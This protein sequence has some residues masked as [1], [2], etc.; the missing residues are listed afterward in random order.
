MTNILPGDAPTADATFDQLSRQNRALRL[1]TGIARALN[2]HQ[3]EVTMLNEV[4]QL[5]VEIGNYPV[6]WIA[7]AGDDESGKIA[8]LAGFCTGN[9][10]HDIQAI[11]SLENSQDDG[12]VK[13]AM[14]SGKA[15]THADIG[16]ASVQTVW[17]EQALKQGLRSSIALPLRDD[18]R[19][20]GTLNLYAEHPGSFSNDEL[21]LLEDIVDEIGFGIGMQRSRLALAE[22]EKNLRKAQD[23]AHLGHFSF[24]PIK[25]QWR[26]SSSLDQIFGISADYPRTAES[27]LD[28]VHPEDQLR[29]SVYLSEE[30]IGQRRTF[31]NEYRI[32][33]PADG[34]TRWVHGSGEVNVNTDNEVV[35]MFGAI[36]DITDRR[37]AEEQLTKLSLALEQSPHSILITN[38]KIEIEYI[39]EGF[40]QNTGYNRAEVI[41]RKPS[42]LSSGLTPQA[43]YEKL[44]ATLQRGE[45]WR[46]EFKNRRKDGE[47]RDAF[48]IISPVRQDDGRISHFLSIEEDITEKK[49][50]AE[51]LD[52]HRHHLEALVRDRTTELSI[53]KEEAEAANRA[54]TS[55]VANMSHEIRTPMNAIIGLT[56]LV[57]REIDDPIQQQRL[58]K[59]AD[60]AQHLLSIINDILDISKI[61]AGKMVLEA[62]PF[63]VE[64]VFNAAHSLINERAQL[65][66]LPVIS[67]IDPGLPALL[68][69]DPLRLQQILVNFLSN[70]VKFTEKGDIRIVARTLHENENG[71][72]VRFEVRDTGIGMSED[73]QARL[74]SPFEQADSSTTRRYGGTGLGLAISRRLAEAMGGTIGVNSQPGAGSTFWFT[75]RLA[76]VTAGGEAQLLQTEEGNDEVLIRRLHAGARVLLVEDNVVNQ[77]VALDLLRHAGLTADLAQ[78]G[79]EATVMSSR[80]RYDL[81]LMDMQMPVLDGIGATRVIRAMPQGAK[82]PI[83]AMTANAFEEDR[84][85]CLD[86]GMN[87]FITK[88]VDPAT[89]L[90]VLLRWL[91]K[92]AEKLPEAA[93]NTPGKAPIM[94][95]QTIATADETAILE[96]LQSVDGLDLSFGLKAL[97]GRASSYLR[98]LKKFSEAHHDDF[99]QIRQQIEAGN[100]EDAR[101]LAH[102]LKG[103]SGSL[104]AVAIQQAAARLEMAIRGTRPLAEID[105]E[106]AET[107]SCYQTLHAALAGAMRNMSPAAI[108]A[109]NP[110]LLQPLVARVRDLLADGDMSVQNLVRENT[111]LLLP[112]FGD[113]LEHFNNLVSGFDFEAALSLMTDAC[114]NHPALAELTGSPANKQE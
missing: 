82:I 88:P 74:F 109:P 106:I 45:V 55:F 69:G 6:A 30:V 101:R 46:G 33:R 73:T 47:I 15:V 3:D 21:A 39:N 34:Q 57:Q 38:E 93:A 68:L 4:C 9:G 19:I 92:P 90:R 56:H 86:A 13:R 91:P 98:L 62:T 25:D 61:E 53:A 24:D 104:G 71:I 89:L 67:E 23:M 103:A 96:H 42:L 20:I 114:R 77:E 11:I 12:P 7:Q 59:V 2:R 50:N 105:R 95:P 26:C 49:R 70:A 36:Q 65:K 1:L 113:R 110:A 99:G 54:K 31:D 51:E 60:A 75:A 78:H 81:I 43:T 48:A 58:E 40:V 14:R 83:V 29:M 66:S 52:R 76:R 63:S 41:G 18:G 37:Q 85:R 5:A 108:S 44:W 10:C 28:L 79:A 97:R 107:A 8:P 72:L 100:T 27:W 22:S 64:A 16:A 112:L 35:G 102:S 32:I 87:D 84:Q 17:R 111:G 94:T 80:Q